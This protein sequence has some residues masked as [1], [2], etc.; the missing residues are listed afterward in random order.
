MKTKNILYLFLIL[1]V[2]GCSGLVGALAGGGIL[3]TRLNRSAQA[4]SAPVA[5][6]PSATPESQKLSVSN[7]EIE[8]TIT[9]V[10]EK[11]EPAVVTVNGTI[12]GTM[13]FFGA[14]ADQQVSGSGIIVSADGYILTNNHV[15]ESTNQL[16]VI[17]NDGAELPA[18]LISTDVFADLAVIKVEGQMPAVVTLGNSD[19]LKPGETVI[20]I[21][22]PLGDFRN[23]VTVGVISATGR[24]LDTGNG[25]QMENLIRGS[26]QAQGSSPRGRQVD[27]GQV[28]DKVNR[29]YFRGQ[30]ERPQLSWSVKRSYRRLGTYSAQLDQVTVSRTLDNRE[31]P[32]YVIEY[33]MYHELLHKKLGVQRANSGKRNHTKAFKELEKQFNYYEEA[34]QYLKTL[35]PK[36]R[37]GIFR[38][39]MR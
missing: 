26:Q 34:N 39:R 11:V 9:Q 32:V 6:L 25:Y 5:L 33:I 37:R 27:L 31:I 28:F 38:L 14:S 23:S 24:T 15:V 21:G 20:A 30:L 8:T 18:R 12:S 29:E 2:A 16:N 19:Q 4:A 22:S 1:I 3:Y 17:L 10:V 13:T 35:A 7:T 36:A